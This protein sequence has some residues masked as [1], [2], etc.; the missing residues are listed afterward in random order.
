[1]GLAYKII[2]D[3]KVAVQLAEIRCF[4]GAAFQFN[5]NEGIEFTVE[6]EQIYLESVAFYINGILILDK[7]ELFA[8]L[9]NEVADILHNLVFQYFLVH[10]LD[11]ISIQFLHVD[12]VQ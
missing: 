12:E 1:M 10:V 6:E 9:K 2:Q 11:V 4:E 8:K 5:R 7:K 3:G